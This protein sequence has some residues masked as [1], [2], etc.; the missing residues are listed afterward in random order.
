MIF[1]TL[2]GG[3]ANQMFQYAAG[4]SLARRLGVEL[5]LDVS[6]FSEGNEWRM[7]SL[8]LFREI[9]EL[10]ECRKV[11]KIIVEPSLRYNSSLWPQQPGDYTLVGYWQTEQ[12]FAHLREELKRRFEPREPLPARSSQDE[13]LILGQGESSVFVTIRRSDYVNNSFHGTLPME[14]YRAAAD[15]IAARVLNPTFFVFSDEP[16]WCEAN[17][18]LPYWYR[19]CGNFDRTVKPHLGREDAELWLMRQCRHAILANSSYSWWG[20]WLG[21]A[22]EGGIVVAPKQWFLSPSEY[23]GDICPERWIQL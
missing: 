13:R 6:R 11:G 12:Y 2:M 22:D 23:S 4:L 20:A 19:V 3:C 5:R 1:T 18:K 9:P 16:E 14:Y 8:G 17:F 7:F 21:R 15:L 10:G